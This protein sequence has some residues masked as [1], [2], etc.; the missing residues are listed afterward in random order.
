MVARSALTITLRLTDLDVQRALVNGSA[1]IV[2]R[3]E[4]GQPF[5]VMGFTVHD[6]RVLE[7]DVLFDL[8]RL[9]RLDLTRLPPATS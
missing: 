5:S 3:D 1:G 7:I 6:G 9:R 4:N 2:S 8:E